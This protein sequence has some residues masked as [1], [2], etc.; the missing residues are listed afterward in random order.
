LKV[1]TEVVKAG[2]Q[3][4]PVKGS[5][6]ILDFNTCSRYYYASHMYIYIHTY[7][8]TYIHMYLHITNLE[9]VQP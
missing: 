6:N 8:H 5:S 2:Y 3:L 7:I 1:L 9:F 4:K